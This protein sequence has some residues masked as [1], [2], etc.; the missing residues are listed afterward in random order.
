M[1]FVPFCAP[2]SC[3]TPVFLGCRYFISPN[4]EGCIIG[5]ISW[6]LGIFINCLVLTWVTLYQRPPILLEVRLT[7]WGN[8]GTHS[9]TR[10]ARFLL[11]DRGLTVAVG[12]TSGRPFIQHG[13]HSV[14]V[15]VRSQSH[16]RLRLN[17]WGNLRHPI[18]PTQRLIA[19]DLL[20]AL[21]LLPATVRLPQPLKT[22]RSSHSPNRHPALAHNS[23]ACTPATAHT[24]NKERK[25]PVINT[26][27]FMSF[28]LNQA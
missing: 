20:R 2:L 22:S 16:P 19:H 26:F 28:Q 18:H 1:L 24:E 11:C 21:G 13:I 15:S 5:T 8:L 4:C 27:G 14:C 6:L 9:S 17:R 23:T 25:A 7:P 10:S 3:K 12:V